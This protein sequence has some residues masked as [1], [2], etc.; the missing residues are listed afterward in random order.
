MLTTFDIAP[1]V[2]KDNTEVLSEGFW[3]DADKIRF[4]NVAGKSHPEVVGGQQTATDQTLDGTC[5]SMHEWESLGGEKWVALGTNTSLYIFA[6][7]YLWNITPLA[8][9]GTLTGVLATTAGTAAVT[10]TH[11]AHGLVTGDKAY[12]HNATAVGGISLGVTSTLS[13]DPIQTQDGGTQITVVHTAHDLSDGD[14]TIFSGATAVGGISATAINQ[15]HSILKLDA[16]A[17]VIDVGETGTANAIGGGTPTVTG[18]KARTVTVVDND[19]YTV[20]ADAAASGTASAGGGT[21]TYKYE[22]PIG[23]AKSVVS[24]GY[25]T[26]GYSESGYSGF[27]GVDDP[28]ARVWT[29]SNQGQNLIANYREGKL[30]RWT[31]VLSQRAAVNAATDAPVKTLHHLTTPERFLICLGTEDATTSTYDPMLVAW[32][33]QEG[34]FATSDWTPTATN[35]A[36]DFRLAEG[37]RIMRGLALRRSSRARTATGCSTCWSRNRKPSSTPG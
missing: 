33:T 28:I 12:L 22:V 3:S 14:I 7:G 21:L 36:G 17:Y 2:I 26:G 1:G 35:T 18:L 25:S 32:A 10:V 19:T 20:T 24:S 30:Y 9:Q 31:G 8:S 5:R 11:T 15:A 37:A 16:D 29:L 23:F 6:Q 4:R 27:L 13:A 34:G